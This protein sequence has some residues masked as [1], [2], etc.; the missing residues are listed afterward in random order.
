MLENCIQFLNKTKIG[1]LFEVNSMIDENSTKNSFL[2]KETNQEKRVLI[3]L[4][5]NDAQRY[6]GSHAKNRADD[7]K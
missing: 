2:A 7:E 5:L 6:R 4:A 3:E 1:M